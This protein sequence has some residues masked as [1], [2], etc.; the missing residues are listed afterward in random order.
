MFRTMFLTVL[1]SPYPGT[2]PGIQNP[3]RPLHRLRRE[4]KLAA[5]R[6]QPQIV[7]QVYRQDRQSGDPISFDQDDNLPSRSFSLSSFGR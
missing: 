4:T 2:R 5:Q 3:L 1:N 7:G 6:Q